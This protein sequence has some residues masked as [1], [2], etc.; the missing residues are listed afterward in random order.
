MSIFQTYFL[1]RNLSPG[2]TNSF[3]C[4]NLQPD[5]FWSGPPAS[6]PAKTPRHSSAGQEHGENLLKCLVSSQIQ[7]NNL[8]FHFFPNLH[9]SLL[10]FEVGNR[11][12]RRAEGWRKGGVRLHD[13]VFVFKEFRLAYKC[14]S[15]YNT[16]KVKLINL[17]VSLLTSIIRGILKKDANNCQRPPGEKQKNQKQNKTKWI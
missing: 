12:G 5:E 14:T 3:V 7:M 15:E 13:S 11:K 16:F 9:L 4:L 6:P 1:V 10:R 2:A 17:L 8:F